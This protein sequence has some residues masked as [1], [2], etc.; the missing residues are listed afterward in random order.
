MARELT[1]DKAIT[2]QLQKGYDK[3]P[4]CDS[5]NIDAGDY[6]GSHGEL[7][8]GV[9]CNDCGAEWTEGYQFKWASIKE[10]PGE[11]DID[12][13][14]NPSPNRQNECSSCGRFVSD[15]DYVRHYD[16]CRSC[17]EDPDIV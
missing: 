14:M 8:C 3:C 17:C 12:V 15:E 5:T 1:G 7:T 2:E 4:F 13:M 11:E 16:K 10:Q 9:E 6:D